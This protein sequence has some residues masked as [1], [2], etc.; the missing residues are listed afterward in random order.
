MATQ[1]VLV[2]ALLQRP[3]SPGLIIWSREPRLG[4]E[5]RGSVGTLKRT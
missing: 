5:A 4:E 2:R 1:L 3:W